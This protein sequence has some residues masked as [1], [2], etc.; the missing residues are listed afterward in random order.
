M[1]T[2]DDALFLGT[3]GHVRAVLKDT[4]EAIW[5]TSLPG[6]GYALVTLL[7]EDGRLFAGSR[8]HLYCLDPANGEI[9]WS[10]DLKGLGYDFMSLTTV[11][12]AGT[13]DAAIHVAA[14][15]SRSNANDASTSS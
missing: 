12:S 2:V 8:G 10:D 9:L 15:A 6:C 11:R 5:T 4:G 1:T 14:A 7:F 13:S 3:H